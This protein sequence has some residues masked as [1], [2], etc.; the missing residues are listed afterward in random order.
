M[1]THGSYLRNYGHIS[2]GHNVLLLSG[3][4]QV[5]TPA[6]ALSALQP[7]T[8]SIT[9]AEDRARTT[10]TFDGLPKD[11]IHTRSMV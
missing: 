10:I 4:N 8:W 1:D 2:R 11:D 9:A 6:K 3:K 5:E 7:G